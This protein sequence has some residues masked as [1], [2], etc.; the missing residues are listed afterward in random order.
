MQD[1][2]GKIAKKQK[3]LGVWLKWWKALPHKHQ[4][5]FILHYFQK[6]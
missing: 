6:N 4:A 3:G 5:R 1:P 2:V